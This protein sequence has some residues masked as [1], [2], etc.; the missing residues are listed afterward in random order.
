MQ[1]VRDYHFDPQEAQFPIH[2]GS[3]LAILTFSAFPENHQYLQEA[4]LNTKT[5]M[6]EEDKVGIEI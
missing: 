2:W 6:F 5:T 1:L 3:L 4:N